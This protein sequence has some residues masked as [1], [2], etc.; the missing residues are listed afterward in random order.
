MTEIPDDFSF[1]INTILF[2]K[3]LQIQDLLSFLYQF[4]VQYT[5]QVHVFR[6]LKILK[7]EKKII[8]HPIFLQ[9]FHNKMFQQ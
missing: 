1:N 3:I 9:K 6:Q 7:K 5:K 2:C 4:E 8:S